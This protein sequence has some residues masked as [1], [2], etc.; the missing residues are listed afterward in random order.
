MSPTQSKNGEIWK[1]TKFKL[2]RQTNKRIVVCLDYST[3]MGIGNRFEQVMQAAVQ[4]LSALPVNSYVGLIAFHG[5]VQKLAD[6]T[7]MR[8]RDS[9]EVLKQRLWREK[10]HIGTSIGGAL[11]MA[12]N[13]LKSSGPAD[14]YDSGGSIIIL[15]DGEETEEPH[16]NDVFQEAVES[17]ASVN[18]IAMGTEASSMLE[19]LSRATGGSSYFSDPN[20]PNAILQDAFIAELQKD[21]NEAYPIVSLRKPVAAGD[22]E[23]FNFR[24]DKTIGKD[25]SIVITYTDEVNLHHQTCA[26][27]GRLLI[28][29]LRSSGFLKFVAVALRLR[30]NC[31]FVGHIVGQIVGHIM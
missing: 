10:L 21:E 25:T 9:W 6:L 7:L 15:T 23:E 8:D 12:I 26:A 2:L 29:R 19:E 5:R 27:V 11:R 14:L 30:P 17:G 22:T 20:S 18:T 24:I 28:L 1:E 3:S 4:Y 16:I 13:I 31:R